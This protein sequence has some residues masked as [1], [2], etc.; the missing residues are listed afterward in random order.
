MSEAYELVR[1]SGWQNAT[2]GRR[3][4]ARLFCFADRKHFPDPKIDQPK[5]ILAEINREIDCDAF[6]RWQPGK[7]PEKHEEMTVLEKVREENRLAQ[8]RAERKAEERERKEDAK[9]KRTY[10]LSLA[11]FV[12]SALMGIANFVFTLLRH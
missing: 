1:E 9:H 11:A 8:E 3:T 12:F 7:S 4:G 6:V 2:N 5:V 10:R